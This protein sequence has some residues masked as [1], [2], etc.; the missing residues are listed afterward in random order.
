MLPYLQDNDLSSYDVNLE[1]CI[2]TPAMSEPHKIAT[3]NMQYLYY[4]VA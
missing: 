2:K 1:M 4:S 3:S